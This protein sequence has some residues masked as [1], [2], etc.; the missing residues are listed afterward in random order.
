MTGDGRD[1]RYPGEPL[2]EERA[3]EADETEREMDEIVA[4]HVD[5]EAAG[6]MAIGFGR[7]GLAWISKRSRA[8][9]EAREQ[10][11]LDA[12]VRQD[13]EELS[14]LSHVLRKHPERKVRIFDDRR[15][16]IGIGFLSGRTTAGK[17]V[18]WTPSDLLDRAAFAEST[19]GPLPKPLF[20]DLAQLSEGAAN[21]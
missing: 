6:A 10:A 2:A 17:S 1:E 19:T 5:F 7:G 15:R 8:Q 3:A 13:L 11:V 4:Q 16:Q 12:E 9:L 21:G 18:V 14:T 20:G